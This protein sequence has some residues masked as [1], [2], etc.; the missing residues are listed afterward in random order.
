MSLKV[1]TKLTPQNY[2]NY[3]HD[4]VEEVCFTTHFSPGYAIY[5]IEKHLL[6]MLHSAHSTDTLVEIYWVHK[7]CKV[8]MLI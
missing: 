3:A 1:Y 8:G 7:D 4:N 2:K 5:K 6:T